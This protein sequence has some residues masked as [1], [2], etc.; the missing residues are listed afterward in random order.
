MTAD[1]STHLSHGRD[2][3]HLSLRRL[4]SVQHSVARRRDIDIPYS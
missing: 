3:E 2:L 4:H 1:L